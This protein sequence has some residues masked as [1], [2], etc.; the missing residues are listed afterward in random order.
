M[1]ASNQTTNRSLLKKIKF[2]RILRVTR[3]KNASDVPI[4][5]VAKK[6]LD[7]NLTRSERQSEGGLDNGRLIPKLQMEIPPNKFAYIHHGD[8]HGIEGTYIIAYAYPQITDGEIPSFPNV[9]DGTDQY[10]DG[11]KGALIRETFD[12][13]EIRDMAELRLTYNGVKVGFE[14]EKRRL[15]SGISLFVGDL[16]KVVE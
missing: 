12:S 14:Y 13:Y 5:W 7:S 9:E 10:P 15:P 1:A 8:Y 16:N 11:T 3:V 4:L 2:P 6:Y